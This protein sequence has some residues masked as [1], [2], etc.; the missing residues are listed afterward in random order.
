MADTVDELLSVAERLFAEKG[1]EH[2]ALTHIVAASS[3]RNRSALHYH[4]GARGGVLTAVLNRRLVA[5]NLRRQ[6]LLDALPPGPTPLQILRASTA[7]LA[8]IAFE[9]PWGP[10]YISILAQVTFH[11]RL[12]GERALADEHLSGLRRTQ[13]LLAQALPQLPAGLVV[14]RLR[15]FTDSVVFTLARCMRDTPDAGRNP[16]AM[17]EL[18]EQLVAYGTA[19]LGA[20]DPSTPLP[21]QEHKP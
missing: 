7:P 8:L 12:L 1:V 18:T 17:G 9:E 20:P 3:Q 19:G 10:D 5:I 13:S 14:Q 4:F 15:W 21:I 2:V 6:A 11:P 16:A